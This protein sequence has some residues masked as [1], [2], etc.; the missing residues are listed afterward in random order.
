MFDEFN[1]SSEINCLN[2]SP[3]HGMTRISDYFP[4][5]GRS[6]DSGF[7]GLK[8]TPKSASKEKF[9]ENSKE[10]PKEKEY[11]QTIMELK[12][13]KI[14]LEKQMQDLINNSHEKLNKREHVIARAQNVLKGLLRDSCVQDK[15]KKREIMYKNSLELANVVQERC[16]TPYLILGAE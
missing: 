4:V 5:A 14:H 1:P 15:K 13:D 16:I 12:E 2:S 9:K 11:L 8:V 7:K 6:I 10:N 3:G